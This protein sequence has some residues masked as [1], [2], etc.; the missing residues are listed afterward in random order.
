MFPKVHIAFDGAARDDQVRV[1]LGVNSGDIVVATV[2]VTCV[3]GGALS[4]DH[5]HLL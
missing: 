5:R 1:T 2:V 4:V 3:N